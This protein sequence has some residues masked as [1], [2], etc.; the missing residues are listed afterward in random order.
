MFKRRIQYESYGDTFVRI[1]WF[2]GVDIDDEEE[3]EDTHILQHSELIILGSESRRSTAPPGAS[4]VGLALLVLEPLTLLFSNPA[5]YF[6]YLIFYYTCPVLLQ[7]R[8]SS[9]I[10]I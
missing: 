4:A 10:K 2:I 7:C 3:E 5:F 8:E 6:I 1:M 9:L